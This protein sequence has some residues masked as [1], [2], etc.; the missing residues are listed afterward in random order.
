[1]K[2]YFKSDTGKIAGRL[3]WL[4]NNKSNS[5]IFNVSNPYTL[6]F[7]IKTLKQYCKQP[8]LR[9]H[10]N[11]SFTPEICKYIKRRDKLCQRKTHS[12]ELIT[13]IN[14]LNNQIA[15]QKKTNKIK[16]SK[17]QEE[18]EQV[19]SMTKVIKRLQN[20]QNNPSPNI[21]WSIKKKQFPLINKISFQFPHST[22]RKLVQE[23]NTPQQQNHHHTTETT[24][25]NQNPSHHL[26]IPTSHGE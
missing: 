17:K 1:M 5:N 11:A 10:D 19:V 25:L 16:C 3:S 12:P 13:Q 22:L 26:F 14:T 6:L 21:A 20:S 15:T 18:Q 2:N 23:N 7:A 4:I 24:R 9:T 8:T